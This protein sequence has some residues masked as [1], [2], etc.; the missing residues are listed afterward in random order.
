MSPQEILSARFGIA[1]FKPGQHAVIEQL[2]AGNSA[3]AVFPTGGGKSLCYQLPALLLPGLTLVVSPL[4]ALMKDQIDALDRRGIAAARID[5][6]LAAGETAAVMQRIRSGE[7]KLLYVAPERFNNERFRE[8]IERM[9]VS[10]FAVDEAHCISEWGHNFRPDYLKLVRFANRCRAERLLALTATATP[11]VLRDICRE[12]KIE[13]QAAIRTGFF[14]PNLALQASTVSSPNR[15]ALLIEKLHARPPGA[16][17]VYV[18]LQKTAEQVA[19]RLAAAGFAA[20]AYHAGLETEERTAVQNW[21]R[22]SHQPIVVATIAFGMG[23]DKADIRY[24]YHYNLPKSLENY[25]QEIGRSGRDG[26]PATCELLVCAADLQVLENFALGDTPSAEAVQSLVK[27]IFRQPE[28][29]DVSLYDLSSKHDIKQLVV[30]TLLVYLELGEW[31][32]EGT[33]FYDTYSFQPHCTSAEIL[34]QFEGE[35]REFLA[36]VLRQAQKA[37]TWFKLDLTRAS[38]VTGAPRDRIVRALDYLAEQKLLTLKAE[39]VRNRFTLLRKPDDVVALAAE[40]HA[41]LVARETRE[42]DRLQQ[43]LSLVSQ[44]SCIT[45]QLCEHFGETLNQPCGTCTFCVTGQPLHLET[46]A[47]QAIPDKLWQQAL[48]LRQQYEIL[49]SPRDFTRFLCGLTSPGLTKARASR[50]ALFGSL[51]HIP[52]RQIYQRALQ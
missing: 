22:D 9:H 31:I 49:R 10:L 25:S 2:L 34:Q 24:V 46:P 47:E 33:A 28:Q 14:R 19:E 40:L 1:A 43:V 26:L 39:G 20:K 18:T 38:E 27:Y 52:Y 45:A 48:Q 6:T 16:S 37:K 8:A 17:I 21:F 41:K 15:D 4:I 3:A 42:L 44:P 32:E 36:S 30:R 51:T 29:F 11:E 13:P 50:E 23:I 7:I 12:F 35:R 5:S